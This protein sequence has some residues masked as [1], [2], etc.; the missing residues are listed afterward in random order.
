MGKQYIRFSQHVSNC[1]I[2][3]YNSRY[4]SEMTDCY[5]RFCDPW[6]CLEIIY[7]II[8]YLITSLMN[9]DVI[10]FYIKSCYRILLL[11]QNVICYCIH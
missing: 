4:N 5:M 8:Y 1:T 11:T 9:N 7:D 10:I 2:R 3:A 6:Y